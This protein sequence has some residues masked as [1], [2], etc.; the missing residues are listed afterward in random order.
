M[1]VTGPSRRVLR[2]YEYRNNQ[3]KRILNFSFHGIV[4]VMKQKASEKY[5]QKCSFR[6]RPESLNSLM[7]LSISW[8]VGKKKRKTKLELPEIVSRAYF[9]SVQ[10][11]NYSLSCTCKKL[12]TFGTNAIFH[13]FLIHL[14]LEGPQVP[15]QE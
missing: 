1:I 13:N 14:F 15:V 9:R 6:L 8:E 11:C 2:I 12:A 5:R 7:N 3:L 10:L 4:E